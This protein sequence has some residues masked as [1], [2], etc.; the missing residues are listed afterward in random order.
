MKYAISKPVGEK[1]TPKQPRSRLWMVTPKVW[2]LDPGEAME[3]D[4]KEEAKT[5]RDLHRTRGRV[6]KIS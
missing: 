4:T 6:Q 5:F 2:K 3:F 1:G